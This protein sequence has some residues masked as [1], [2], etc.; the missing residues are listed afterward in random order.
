M[1][2]V[3]NVSIF[4]SILNLIIVIVIAFGCFVYFFTNN[5]DTDTDK[6]NVPIYKMGEPFSCGDFRYSVNGI[7]WLNSS[8]GQ[9]FNLKPRFSF[10]IIKVSLSNWGNR[11][12]MIPLF[13]LIDEN[14]KQYSRLVVS[15]HESFINTGINIGTM[16]GITGKL[17]FDVPTEHKYRLLF[18]GGVGMDID[19]SKGQDK[20]Q[21]YTE[22]Y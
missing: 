8:Y 13:H 12:R 3:K 5:T 10:L 21:A 15:P 14:G 7:S 16:E 18:Y 11:A 2:E 1:N 6:N 9:G 17:V 20:K 4:G 22:L 19:A